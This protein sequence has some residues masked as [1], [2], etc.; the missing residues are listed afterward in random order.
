M[1]TPKQTDPQFKLR[2]TSDLKEA[3][4]QA[5]ASNNRSMNAEIVDRLS[6]SVQADSDANKAREEIEKLREQVAFKDGVI[7]SL[8]NNV[9]VFIKHLASTESDHMKVL[10]RIIAEI[11]EMSP[12]KTN[13]DS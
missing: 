3:I 10:D 4:E 2:L 5:A 9:H 11:K 6:A 8:R 12:A 1:A 7:S 13:V